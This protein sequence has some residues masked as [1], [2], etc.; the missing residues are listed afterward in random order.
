M[1]VDPTPM[2]IHDRSDSATVENGDPNEGFRIN[3]V[4]TCEPGH[5]N[6]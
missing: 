2:P 6:A 5:G 3:T 1:M 4:T